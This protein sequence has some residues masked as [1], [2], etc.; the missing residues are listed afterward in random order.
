MQEDEHLNAASTDSHSDSNLKDLGQETKLN[1]SDI[2][3][4]ALQK[5]TV[6]ENTI[7]EIRIKRRRMKDQVNKNPINTLDQMF[8]VRSTDE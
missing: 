6:L 3:T 1:A 2:E 7:S 8:D 4:K 5:V